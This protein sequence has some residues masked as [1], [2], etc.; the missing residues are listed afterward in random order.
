MAFTDEGISVCSYCGE[1]TGKFDEHGNHPA[2]I[3]ISDLRAALIASQQETAAVRDE[4]EKAQA[5]EK[6]LREALTAL[7]QDKVITGISAHIRDSCR[8][9]HQLPARENPLE[10]ARAA[11]EL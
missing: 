7:S 10:L 3:E 9:L 8:G 4:L 11:L 1:D 2:C 5:R 6:K